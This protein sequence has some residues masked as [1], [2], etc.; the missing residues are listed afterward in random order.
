MV[1]GRDSV[2]KNHSL[3]GVTNITLPKS[4]PDLLPHASKGLPMLF[5]RSGCLSIVRGQG[6]WMGMS[7]KLIFDLTL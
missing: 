5:A 1:E 7:T 3:I 4:A 2:L 6:Y